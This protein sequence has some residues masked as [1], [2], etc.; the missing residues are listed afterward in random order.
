[1]LRLAYAKPVRASQIERVP[2]V[3]GESIACA[4]DRPV[5]T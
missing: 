4:V 5:R 1:M 2:A 3:R